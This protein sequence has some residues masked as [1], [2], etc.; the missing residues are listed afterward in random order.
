M[1]APWNR[2]HELYLI[3]PKIEWNFL[4]RFSISIL[5]KLWPHFEVLGQCQETAADFFLAYGLWRFTANRF[6]A[7][8][9]KSKFG[10]KAGKG[11]IRRNMAWLLE[12]CLFW[13]FFSKFGKFWPV[14]KKKTYFFQQFFKE[15]GLNEHREINFVYFN[16]SLK[17]SSQF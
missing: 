2:H 1:K 4:S 5:F 8:G 3:K 7:Y 15:L 17:D 14:L 12:I 11:I 6:L 9:K 13:L 10:E 16:S